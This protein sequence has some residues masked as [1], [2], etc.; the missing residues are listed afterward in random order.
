MTAYAIDYSVKGKKYW[1]TVDAKDLKSA[2][3]KLAKKHK[4][5]TS[6]GI[7]VE[8]VGVIGYL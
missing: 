5:N 3:N 8:R 1:D 4:L 2:K 7:K 6:R